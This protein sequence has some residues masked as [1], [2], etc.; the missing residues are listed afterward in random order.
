MPLREENE[1]VEYIHMMLVRLLSLAASIVAASSSDVIHFRTFRLRKSLSDPTQGLATEAKCTK[2][3]N[4]LAKALEQTIAEKKKLEQQCAINL[5][6][7]REMNALTQ[8]QIDRVKVMVAERNDESDLPPL[9]KAQYT[10]IMCSKLHD[11][12]IMDGN[13]KARGEVND[14]C[15]GTKSLR[16][17]K[18]ESLEPSYTDDN[19]GAYHAN[20]G[21]LAKFKNV[22]EFFHRMQP[23]SEGE[24]FASPE[25]FQAQP[26]Q[27]EVDSTKQSTRAKAE[28]CSK[29]EKR[30]KF[31]LEQKRKTEDELWTEY[32]GHISQKEPIR[33]EE[34]AGVKAKFCALVQQAPS[35]G[36]KN[37]RRNTFKAFYAANCV[38]RY[39][40]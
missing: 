37:D 29:E 27:Q 10:A 11:G 7:Y 6:H 5:D 25:C 17:C 26:L 4:D 18:L 31:D 16:D 32:H 19:Y 1:D 28:Y 35:T 22:A 36:C 20:K 23:S 9:Y 33:K 2:E 24:D 30:L 3:R 21:H 39:P 13:D 38:S 14:I 40:R 8:E 12:F 15:N 34:A